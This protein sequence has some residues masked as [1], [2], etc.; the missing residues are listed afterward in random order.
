MTVEP[1]A[2]D[3]D[4]AAAMCAVSPDH[5]DRHIRGELSA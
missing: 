2:V 3:H 5:F 4:T 1:V